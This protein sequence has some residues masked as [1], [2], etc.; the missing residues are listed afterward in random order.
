M[1][2]SEIAACRLQMK[3]NRVMDPAFDLFAQQRRPDCVA[4]IAAD[5]GKV[6]ARLAVLG[7]GEKCQA[8]VR[9]SIA[10]NIGKSPTPRVP[11]LEALELGTQHRRLKSVE[12]R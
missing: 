12:P 3:R 9:Q 1:A 7:L 5:D 6:V 10:I 2:V 4:A 8:L 11:F